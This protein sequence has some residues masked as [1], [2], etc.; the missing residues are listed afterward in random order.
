MSTHESEYV[1]NPMEST[2]V[3]AWFIRRII[4]QSVH[5]KQ[6]KLILNTN[7]L[8]LKEKETSKSLIFTDGLYK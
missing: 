6:H 3:N 7:S 2:E 4:N 5:I 1:L 8:N